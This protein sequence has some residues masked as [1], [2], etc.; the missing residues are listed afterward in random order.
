M[1]YIFR[2]ST[3]EPFFLK[4]N[5]IFSGYDDI[6]E[7]NTDPDTYI[8]FY[9]L[10]LKS[11][12]DILVEEIYTYY[13]S[14]LLVYR[15][16]PDHKNF[17]ILTLVQ[18]FA[19]PVQ[20]GNYSLIEAIA[21]FN[22][23][24]IRLAKQHKN[25]KI[26]DFY[27]FTARFSMSQLIDWKFYY[28]SKMPLN[29]KLSGP[30]KQWF[31]IQT[32][33]IGMKRKKCLVLDLDNTLWGG[34]LGE[35]GIYG[36]KSGG[37]YPGNAFLDFQKS[38]LELNK[39]GI[40]LTICSKNN[41]ADVV[42]LWEKN[43]DILIKRDHI[44]I[45]RINWNN[46]V[47]NITE[48]IA[49][50]NIG[51]DSVVYIDD[52]PSE[53]ELVKQFLPMIETPEFPSQP[54]LL[55]AF[56]KEITERYFR[57][58]QITEEDRLKTRQYQENVMRNNYEQ[59]FSDF[60]AYLSSLQME[61]EMKEVQAGNIPRIAQL[62]QKTNQ[63]NLTTKRYTES[64][65]QAFIAQGHTIFS[66]R[67]SDKFGEHGITG[68]IIVQKTEN[69]YTVE[70]DTFLLSCRILGKGIAEAFAYTVFSKLKI[71]GI[72]TILASYVP[73]NKNEQVNDFYD[74]LGF[75]IIDKQFTEEGIKKYSIDLTKHNFEIKPYYKINAIS[76]E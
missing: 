42:E 38:L 55:P 64:E 35:D 75:E 33:A 7:T 43:P 28:L 67:V 16:I 46:K 62:T 32:D 70:I 65:I 5:S 53:R 40:I 56:I 2:N 59:G 10:P 19:N 37:E 41:E 13:N 73:T 15:N 3:L 27:D 57:I 50:L 11:D 74:K 44:T 52:N 61:L 34:I 66:L 58:Y 71:Q 6:S 12:Y 22:Q 26:I 20:T 49:E 24:I 76:N 8:W 18:I 23:K 31:T 63:F 39:T 60:T 51:P 54:Y 36:V 47:E 9:I 69:E 48:I 29:P 30:F 14:L 1:H 17:I 4:H 25:I 68:L 72:K 45:Y 21:D